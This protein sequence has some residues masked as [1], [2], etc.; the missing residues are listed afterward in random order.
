MK[1]LFLILFLLAIAYLFIISTDKKSGK[2]YPI[3]GAKEM[4]GIFPGGMYNGIMFIPGDPLGEWTKT[5]KYESCPACSKGNLFYYWQDEY[6]K[7]KCDECG[8]LHD[9]GEK[10]SPS[11]IEMQ[12]R[13]IKEIHESEKFM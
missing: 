5:E 2:Q 13:I 6:Y 8:Y 1:I 10:L 7:L 9:T 12:N 11:A 4:A 3:M